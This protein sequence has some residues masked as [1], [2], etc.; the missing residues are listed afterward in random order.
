MNWDDLEII[1][2]SPTIDKS[3]AVWPGDVEFDLKTSVDI[4]KGGHLHLSSI[5]T[6]LHLGAHADS[7]LHYESKGCDMASRGLN[8]YIGTC[9]VV[10]VSAKKAE[11]ISLEDFLVESIK[12]PRVLFK[13]NSFPQTSNFNCDF[14]SLSPEVI[15]VLG[16]R[17]VKLVGIDT[18][19]IDPYKSKKLESHKK[20]FAQN[21]AILEGLVLSHVSAH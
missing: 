14:N 11:R 15:Q 2:I 18:P 4:H 3:L 12:A 20:V 17:G 13:T 7:P 16:E 10:E 9:Q 19:S 1:D 8:F 6:T 21:M 5:E